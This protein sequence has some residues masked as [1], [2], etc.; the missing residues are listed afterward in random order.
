MHIQLS[1]FLHFY[2]L[3]LLLNSCDGN[4]VKH[5]VYTEL[6]TCFP[7]YNVGSSKKCR[8]SFMFKVMSVAFTTA[9][10]CFP[11]WLTASSMTFCDM[12]AHVSMRRRFNSLVSRHFRRKYLKENKVS[13]SEGTRKI[14]YAYHFQK[15]AEAVSITVKISL[16]LSKLQL[17]EVGSFF[18]SETQCSYIAKCKNRNRKYTLWWLA[19]HKWFCLRFTSE[20]G[21]ENILTM[22]AY[23]FLRTASR[24]SWTYKSLLLTSNIALCRKYAQRPPNRE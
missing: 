8:F 22:N 7:R 15:C 1:L 20:I 5:N 21:I 13:K 16:C 12:L 9:G 18:F 17:A 23:T 6:W 2:L 3:Y 4:D 19:N 14:E 10:N 11:N 24:M